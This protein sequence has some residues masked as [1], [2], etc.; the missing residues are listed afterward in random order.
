ML[1]TA[2]AVAS[3][4]ERLLELPAAAD[5]AT[6]I[7]C[8]LPALAATALASMALGLCGGRLLGLGVRVGFGLR[9][10]PPSPMSPPYLRLTSP[11]GAVWLVGGVAN[12]IMGS[13]AV[14]ALLNL[15]RFYRDPN[16]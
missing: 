6:A 3:S 7:L 8:L 12:L 11:L 15:V 5:P 9:L 10:A 2:A 14:A 16:P 4:F 13:A 1:A